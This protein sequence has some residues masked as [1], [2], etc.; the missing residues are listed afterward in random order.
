MNF[1]RVAEY[2]DNFSNRSLDDAVSFETRYGDDPR[3]RDQTQRKRIY[4]EIA[5]MLAGAIRAGL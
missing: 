1:E 3:Y 4:A 2:L 5:Y